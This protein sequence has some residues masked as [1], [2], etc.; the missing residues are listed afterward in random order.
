[1]QQELG[2]TGCSVFLWY[3]EEDRLV[4]E[5]SSMDQYKDNLGGLY[6]RWGEE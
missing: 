4:M 3:P 2:I 6:Y 1:M 5:A